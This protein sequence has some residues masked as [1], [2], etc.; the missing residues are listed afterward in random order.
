MAIAPDKYGNEGVMKNNEFIKQYLLNSVATRKALEEQQNA[1]NKETESVKYNLGEQLKQI[2]KYN[3]DRVTDL[4][5]FKD[6]ESQLTE[7]ERKL[8]ATYYEQLTTIE[9][10]HQDVLEGIEQEGARKEKEILDARFSWYFKKDVEA[11][12]KEME[13]RKKRQ[14]NR[15]DEYNN[16]LITN[17][18][19][20]KLRERLAELEAMDAKGVV[21]AENTKREAIEK[22]TEDIRKQAQAYDMNR[23]INRDVTPWGMLKNS[24]YNAGI[25]NAKS[26]MT[27]A[28]LKAGI[29]PTNVT[30]EQA[31]SWWTS[32]FDQYTDALKNAKDMTV[33]YLKEM[34]DAYVELM[35]RKAE[36][37]REETE[38]AKTEYEKEKALLEAGYAN[39]VETTWKTYQEKKAI[40][41]QAEQDAKNA[42]KAMEAVETAQ[43]AVS[44]ATAIAELFKNASSMGVAGVPI[45]VAA[46]TMLVGSFIA[47]KAMAAQAAN[48]GDGGFE[49]LSGGSHASGHD[50]ALGTTN[51]HGRS[52]RAEGGEGLGIFSR[53]AMSR[54]GAG[55]IE[56]VVNAINSGRFGD[57]AYNSLA[58]GEEL[59]NYAVNGRGEIVNLNRIEKSLAN[60]EKSNENGTFYDKDGNRIEKTPYG[61]T[62]YIRK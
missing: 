35:E 37:A 52:M 46:S 49:V 9:R 57:E 39:Q 7:E 25:N 41:E 28:M 14:R 32:A 58:L 11:T 5:N 1:M 62:K 54:Y 53:R 16:N 10:Q 23:Y 48:Y 15:T 33:E 31:E 3:S 56:G 21:E 19:I 18:N 26:L 36:A 27:P 22:T 59:G 42:Q 17:R 4:E 8:Y 47:A 45:A 51:R 30:D 12:E 55:N 24:G 61:T 50:I 20:L 43:Q 2:G 29:D 38:E 34:G 6:F 44:I 40:Q 13:L 60:I